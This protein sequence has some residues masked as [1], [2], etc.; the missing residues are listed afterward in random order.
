MTLKIFIT[1]IIMAD[2]IF[3]WFLLIVTYVTL[4]TVKLVGEKNGDDDDVNNK[5]TW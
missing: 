5:T 2:Y 4:I 1:L 3:I